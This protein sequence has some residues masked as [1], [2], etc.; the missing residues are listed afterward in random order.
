MSGFIKK[1]KSRH[2]GKATRKMTGRLSRNLRHK[3][4]KLP[5]RKK[6]YGLIGHPLSH[7]LSPFIHKSIMKQCGIKGTYKSFDIAP[8]DFDTRVVELLDKLNG[9]NITIP[10]KERIIHLLDTLDENSTRYGAVNTVCNRK[11]YNTDILGFN[12][13]AIDF[14]N[15]K[16]L[17]LGNGGAARIMLPQ[18]LS[19][20]PSEI[21]ICARDAEKTAKLI[22]DTCRKKNSSSTNGNANTDAITNGDNCINNCTVYHADFRD[23]TGVY[24]VILNATP[25]GM[26][27][28]CNEIPVNEDIIKNAEYV[29]DSI[30]NPLATRLLLKARQYG[31][32]ADNGLVMLLQQALF[33][34]QIWNSKA[35]LSV[36]NMNQVLPRMN[37]KLFK[38]FPIKIVLTGFMGSGKTTIGKKLAKAMGIGFA[39]LDLLIV[40]DNRKPISA[41]FKDSGE[42]FFR[43]SEKKCLARIIK[44]PASLVVSTGGGALINPDNTAIVKESQ[45]FIF[46]LATDLETSLKRVGDNQ[47]R[48]L[49]SGK[50]REHIEILYNKRLPVYNSISDFTVD[51]TKRPDDVLNTIIEAIGY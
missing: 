3:L 19:G 10:Y 8:E 7:T 13:C 2:F 44:E 27:P 33:A 46:Y 43:E 20:G 28:H 36:F 41:I 21:C 9:F 6:H 12:A 26:W 49:I 39:D 1:F 15:K 5:N 37:K 14:T 34:Q 17:L 32:R 42:Q 4:R 29:F 45:G 16:V 47:D 31:V 38:H 25:L 23:V 30:Y 48:P 40:E 24:D 11:G 18:A 35:D 51:A 50:D 22:S